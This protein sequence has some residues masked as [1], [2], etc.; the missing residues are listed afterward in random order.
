MQS[1]NDALYIARECLELQPRNSLALAMIGS[2]L[3]NSSAGREKARI[4]LNK[5][6]SIDPLCTTAILGLVRL[7]QLEQRVDSAIS[8]LQRFVGSQTD[9]DFLLV[10]LA[11]LYESVCNYP[12]ALRCLQI[13]LSLSPDLEIA[14]NA[15]EQVESK[16]SISKAS[17]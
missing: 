9:R 15:L 13:A 8:T 14:K 17:I 16:A 6:I 10:K 1:Y 7:D 5:A 4:A 11:L 12:K 3:S 2:V